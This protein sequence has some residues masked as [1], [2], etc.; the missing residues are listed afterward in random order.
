M[1]VVD[2]SFDH[3]LILEEG[4]VLPLA[5]GILGNGYQCGMLWGA[6]LASG[7]QV[8]R[9]Y[10]AGVQGETKAVR[11]AESL[12]KVFQR[13][14]K[15]INCSE[16]TEMSWKGSSTRSLMAQ[17]LKFFLKGGPIVCFSMSASYAK[18]AFNETKITFSDEQ[19]E[20]ALPP[21]SC[22]AMVAKKMGVSDLQ[23]IM[24]AGFAGGIGLSGGGCGA[25]GAAIWIIGM[26]Y[27]RQNNRKPG[28]DNP[29]ASAAVEKYL[30]SADYEFEC[31]KIVGRKFE[32]VADH[33]SYLRDGGCAKIIDALADSG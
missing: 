9:Q 29:L 16:L 21:A 8:Y 31:H 24:A 27:M 2:N 13:R 17:V 22:A 14:N 26:N 20:A 5:G 11:T 6:V 15:Y 12:V 28:L 3:P 19:F 7:A 33:A 32:N 1:S 25:L 10:G 23:T 30:E 4:A 18:Q